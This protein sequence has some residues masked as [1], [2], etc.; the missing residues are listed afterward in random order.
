MVGVQI[1]CGT[2]E[3]PHLCDRIVTESYV[4]VKSMKIRLQKLLNILFFQISVHQKS[5]NIIK[6]EVFATEWKKLL[7]TISKIQ[8]MAHLLTIGNVDGVALFLVLIVCPSPG[9]LQGKP[10]I[11]QKYKNFKIVIRLV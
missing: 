8:Q 10:K 5:Q 3:N 6:V 7:L 2:W 1:S 9:F 4:S 11:Q